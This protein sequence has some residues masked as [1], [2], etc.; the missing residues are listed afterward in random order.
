MQ[1]VDIRSNGDS[2]ILSFF[3]RH[4]ALCLFLML[5]LISFVVYHDFVLLQNVFLYQDIAADSYH[6][7][8]PTLSY[9]AGYVQE[10]GY[11]WW[12]FSMGMGA[13]LYANGFSFGDPFN[14][15]L[16]LCG[17]GAVPFLMGILQFI[18]P[19]CAG[20]FFY[21]FL[22]KIK[23]R[24]D[25]AFLVAIMYAF[26]AHMI[27]RGPW[28]SYPNEVV[29]VALFLYATECFV[30]EHDWKLL[31]VGAAVL[32]LSLK[33]YQSIFYGAFFVFYASIR[34]CSQHGFK[35]KQFSRFLVQYV[36]LVLLGGGLASVILV[37][38]ILYSVTSPR[39][40]GEEGISGILKQTPILQVNQPEHILSAGL[41][42]AAMDILGTGDS[43]TGVA[44]NYL[45]SP[46]FYCG[47]LSVLLFPQIFFLKDK[48]LRIGGIV[49]LAACVGYFFFPFFRYL[50]NGFLTDYYK[51][52][53]FFIT[54]I[55]CY[56]SALVLDEMLEKKTINIPMLV[57]M[58]GVIGC[59]IMIAAFG[60]Y[61]FRLNVPI[62]GLCIAFIGVQAVS[63]IFF[64][65]KQ[66]DIRIGVLLLG[67]SIIVQAGIFAYVSVH[68]G[69]AITP[70]SQVSAQNQEGIYY[71]N[72][73][74]TI[75]QIKA[76]DK[77]FFRLEKDYQESTL[78]T[79]LIQG[80]YGVRSYTTT[81]S[82]YLDFL[83][84]LHIGQIRDM[85]SAAKSNY[86]VGFNNREFLLDFTGIKY[87]LSKNDALDK[88]GFVQR[89]NYKDIYIYQNQNALPLAFGYEKYILREDFEAL[90][91]VEKDVVLLQAFVSESK[92]EG[93]ER[94]TIP[95]GF[96]RFEAVEFRYGENIVNADETVSL[97][98]NGMPVTEFDVVQDKDA[99]KIDFTMKAREDTY[100]Q[101]YFSK[102]KGVYNEDDSQSFQVYEGEHRYSIIVENV[103][104]TNVRIDFGRV[105]GNYQ[106]SGLKFSSMPEDQYRK[107]IEE[108]LSE[109]IESGLDLTYFSDN[110]IKGNLSGNEG[111]MLCFT[112]PYDKGWT[113]MIDGSPARVQKVNVGFIGIEI[114]SGA[115]EIQLQFVPQYLNIGAIATGV[116][117]GIY[118]TLLIFYKKRVRNQ[119]ID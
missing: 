36:L 94:L 39:V 34:F 24:K 101:I 114:P 100:G 86:V 118:L 83:N 32:F 103:N 2:I 116:S 95:A 106:I 70:S 66:M 16:L 77:D 7:T 50:A 113:A 19:I 1:K 96:D 60:K 6:Q 29:W 119:R 110:L 54:V 63:I 23:M 10:H 97:E 38:N 102:E 79:A 78:T 92:I 11:P 90:P 115:K 57:A 44:N 69:R 109:R 30:M 99:L 53:S 117:I 25:T 59:M 46:T 73:K 45:E 26:C 37:P 41:S 88:A 81:G 35:I 9:I 104:S 71:D 108:A 51:H 21:I 65:R 105:E 74:E 85:D 12:S 18:K 48:R 98:L 52:T 4:T 62:T 107:I 58:I 8:Y 20:M 72:T 75:D 56:L 87:L 111:K 49:L 13:N 15:I 17:S 67:I 93:L 27:Q 80:Y 43:F 82:S 14:S 76:E 5:T 64:C 33:G 42:T 91:D 61:G 3:A 112:I 28:F 31:P 40:S 89:G 55:L 68:E 47:T 22:R 84:T